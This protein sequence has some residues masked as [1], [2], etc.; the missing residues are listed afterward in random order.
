MGPRARAGDGMV[1]QPVK[2]A[3]SSTPPARVPASCALLLD[4]LLFF[5]LGA[6]P[7]NCLLALR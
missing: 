4:D 5:F 2:D 3:S 6:S 1:I 7:L